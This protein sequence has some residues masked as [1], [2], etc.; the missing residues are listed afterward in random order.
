ADT[1][2]GPARA[3]A[4]YRRTGSSKIRYEPPRQFTAETL[5]IIQ[6]P[7]NHPSHSPPVPWW[8][9]NHPG[10]GVPRESAV[11]PLA[12]NG[13]EECTAPLGGSLPPNSPPKSQLNRR[14]GR[15]RVCPRRWRIFFAR[16][17]LTLRPLWISQIQWT[18]VRLGNKSTRSPGPASQAGA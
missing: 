9:W 15:S 8:T 10:P 17:R 2:D 16:S 1:G 18:K 4:R 3:V 12:R 6:A 13:D 14:F 5:I 7:R 11:R